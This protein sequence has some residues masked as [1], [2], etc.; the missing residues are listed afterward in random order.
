MAETPAAG[1]GGDSECPGGSAA[2]GDAVSAW[3]VREILPLEA[4]L[5][6]YLHH[7]WR[8]P[9]DITDFRQEI[10]TRVLAAAHDEIPAN[11]KSFL[12]STARNLLI[13]LVKHERVVP[14]EAVADVEALNV[15]IDAAG[16]ERTLVSRDELRH[17]Q[18]ALDRLPA[19]A[20]EAFTLA[21]FED[22]SAQEIA[23]RMGVS[24]AMV[25]KHLA[26]GLRALTDMLSGPPETRHG[27][28]R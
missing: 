1:R 20:R 14:I 24:R 18:A 22:L 25:S 10:Y 6:H 16:P 15:A 27:K 5:M 21:F 12:F 11:A 26:N 8:N 19:R 3:F 4:I 13:N 9:S 28:W 7:N 17:L 2:T 23:A